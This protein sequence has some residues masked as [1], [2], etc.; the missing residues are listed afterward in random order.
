MDQGF[1]VLFTLGLQL[2]AIHVQEVADSLVDDLTDRAQA[3]AEQHWGQCF[4]LLD[5]TI[6]AKGS[7]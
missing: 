5:P 4:S 2:D 6:D 3:Y 1:N 7:L